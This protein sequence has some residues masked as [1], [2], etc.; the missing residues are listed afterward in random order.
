MIQLQ[1]PR[2]K[3]DTCEDKTKIALKEERKILECRVFF[4]HESKVEMH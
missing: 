3:P 4:Q 2:R 1:T